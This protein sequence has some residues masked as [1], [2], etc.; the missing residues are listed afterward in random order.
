M[1]KNNGDDQAKNGLQRDEQ[2]GVGG[3]GVLL[4]DVLDEKR[5]GRVKEHQIENAKG[6][7]GADAI[8]G[9]RENKGGKKR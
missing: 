2:R 7:G 6:A 1:Q 9:R 5:Q 4:G 8:K 3:G